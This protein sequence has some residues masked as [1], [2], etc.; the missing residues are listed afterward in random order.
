M[1]RLPS[2]PPCRALGPRRGHHVLACIG[3]LLLPSG[4]LSPSALGSRV[5]EARSL[6]L[7]VAAWSSHCL[8]FATVLADGPARLASPWAATPSAVGIAPT[9]FSQLH[10]AQG[11][12]PGSGHGGGGRPTPCCT[13]WRWRRR[14][15]CLAGSHAS[16]NCPAGCRTSV[17]W[18]PRPRGT[19]KTSTGRA[20][21]RPSWPNWRAVLGFSTW[22][23]ARFRA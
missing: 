11:I 6:H 18:P 21:S 17:A 1:F 15:E 19:W 8:R 13:A 16:T 22:M 4:C 14:R 3:R 2:F 20:A 10:G 7:T 5:Y 12:H 9:L 23:P